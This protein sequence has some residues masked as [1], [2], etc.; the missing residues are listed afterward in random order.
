MLAPNLPCFAGQG[1]APLEQLRKRLMLHVPESELR[2][3]VRAL[4]F[5]SHDHI[6]T[7]LYDRF[8][9]MSNGIAF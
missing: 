5:A 7:Y 9:R 4:V 2:E 3:R 8:Q 1:S 6:N